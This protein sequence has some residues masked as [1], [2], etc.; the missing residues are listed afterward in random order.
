MECCILSSV[1]LNGVVLTIKTVRFKISAPEAAEIWTAPLFLQL[2]PTCSQRWGVNLLEVSDESRAVQTSV[3]LLTTGSLI[4]LVLHPPDSVSSSSSLIHPS[5]FTTRP[6][7]LAGVKVKRKGSPVVSNSPLGPTERRF[8]LTDGAS[9]RDEDTCEGSAVG[10]PKH[11]YGYSEAAIAPTA[12]II[13]MP[14]HQ[15]LWC[16]L[17]PD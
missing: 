12:Q 2:T 9:S 5:A 7:R 8:L 15:T 6:S 17:A 3:R 14:P 13:S 4:C 11:D 10:T 1:A 16:I